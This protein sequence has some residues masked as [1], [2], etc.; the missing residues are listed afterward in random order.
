MPNIIVNNY[1]NQKCEY[2]FA[3]SNMNKSKEKNMTI[4]LY[5]LVLKFLKSQNQEVRL[6]GGEPLLHPNIGRFLQIANKGGFPVIVFSNINIPNQ[7]IRNIFDPILVNEKFRVNCN[8][9]H[10]SFYSAD[11]WNQIEENIAYLTS[12]WV[13]V[14]LGYN[15]YTLSHDADFIFQLAK[16]YAIGAI[17]LKITNSSLWEN[18]I[19][20]TKSR[21]LGKYI[22]HYI[23][24]YGRGVFIEISCWLDR[25]IFT[26][27]E[28]MFMTSLGMDLRFWCEGNIGRF[29]INTDGTVFKC[30]PLESIY[31]KNPLSIHTIIES[32]L[33]VSWVMNALRETLN[34]F[35]HEN[36]TGECLANLQIKKVA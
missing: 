18:L 14:I 31:K 34:H 20:D 1:C 3:E 2:C 6:L 4:G 32:G 17:N 28:M 22:F 26:E 36:W 35:T 12:R 8:I 23:Q 11:E 16:K 15:I 10:P 19:I 7:K 21:E 25:S 33:D 27:E 24:Q 30:F 13:K 29:D 5:L 9:N